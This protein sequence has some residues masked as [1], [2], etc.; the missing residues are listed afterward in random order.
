M[1]ALLHTAGAPQGR[2]VTDTHLDALAQAGAALGHGSSAE[3]EDGRSFKDLG[4]DSLIAVRFRDFINQELGRSW[5]TMDF[6]S[7]SQ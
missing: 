5:V 1:S 2:T 7:S 3:I 6:R 4:F